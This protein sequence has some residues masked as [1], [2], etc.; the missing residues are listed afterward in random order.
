MSRNVT[1]RDI[2]RLSGVGVSTVSRAINDHPDINPETKE[3]ILQVIRETGFVPNDSARYLK[4]TESNNIALLV[5]GI[6]NPFFMRM[7]RIME[8]YALSRD[9]TTILRHVHIGEDEVAVASSLIRERRIKGIVFLGGKFN[10]DQKSLAQLQV[11][12]IFSTIGKEVAGK[13]ANISVDDVQASREAVEYLISLGHRRIGMITEGMS[14]PSVGQL[15]LQGYREA[16]EAHGIA[17]RPELVF[18]A[19]EGEEHYSMPNGYKGAQALLQANPEMTAL[20]CV[21]DVIAIGACRGI[22]ETGRRIPKDVSVIGFDGI[23]Q[24]EYYI[25]KLTTVAQPVDEMA[26]ETISLLFDI[27]EEKRP[28]QEIIMAAGL[29]VRETTGPAAEGT[30]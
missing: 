14:V 10:H 27:M 5:K 4:R 13:Y 29:R 2:A 12:F 21:S 28:P 11:P 20:F 8:D 16:L 25:P 6:G 23:E 9:Y 15:R 26:E 7:I 22:A 24:G 1:I 18:E 30:L 3:R 19:N 17:Y